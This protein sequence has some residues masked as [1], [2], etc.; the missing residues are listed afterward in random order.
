MGDTVVSGQDLPL[1]AQFTSANGKAFICFQRDGNLVV[2]CDDNKGSWGPRWASHTVGKG[3]DRC[4]MQGDGNL[5]VYKGVHPLWASNTSGHPGA[6]MYVQNDKNVVIYEG[7][8][9]VAALW[10]SKTYDQPE[11]DV[12]VDALP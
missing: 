4:V 6:A 9:G 1:D 10:N 8:L 2:Y 12:R 11:L 5:V 3:A 7:G